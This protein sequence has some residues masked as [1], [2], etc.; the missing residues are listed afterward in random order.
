MRRIHQS[1]PSLGAGHTHIDMLRTSLNLAGTPL[2]VLLLLSA[3]GWPRALTAQSLTYPAAHRDSVI[4]DYHGTKVADPY[5]WLE[6]LDSPRTAEWLKAENRLT[7]DYLGSTLN[8]EAIHRQLTSLWNY[9]RTDVP[10]R[11]AGRLFYVR[12]T[13]LQ[14][15]SVL[16]MQNSLHDPPRS[17]LDPNKISP[18]GSIAVRDYAVSPDGRLLAY[19]TS[20]GGADVG[21]TRVRELSTGRDLAEA[22]HGALTSVCWTHDGR[23][24]FYIRPPAR[25]LEDAAG[26][27]RIEKQLFYHVLGQ[28]QSQDRLIRE[29]KENAKWVYCMLSEDG[30]YAIVVAEQGTESE[31]YAVDLGD[32]KRPDVT[33]PL[34]RLLGD[35]RAFHTPIDIVGSTL[36]VRTNLNAA[37]QRVIALDLGEGASARPRTIIPESSDVIVDA[38]VAGD[39]LAVH[40]LVDVTSRLRLFA[41]DGQPEGEIALPGIGAVGWPLSGRG[42]APELFYSFTSFLAPSTVY[43]HDLRSGASTSFR[44]PRVPFDE[45]AYETRQV[46]YTS[47]NS[48]RV[49][50]FVTTAKNLRLDGTN[51]TL[52]TGYGGYGISIGPSYE[53]DIPLWLE[54]GGIY[55][56]AN[57]RGGGEYGA[58]WHRAGMLERKQNSFDDFIAAAEYLIAERYTAP[59]KLAIYGHSNGGL[60]VGA[61]I[62]QRPDLFAAAVAN[63]GHYD[64]LRYHRFTVG[65]GWIS[66][67]GSPEDPTAFRYLR[68]YSPLH[69]VRT[70]TCYPATL[71]LAADHDDRVVPSHS[72]KFAAVLQAAQGCSRPILLRV[73]TDAS[74]NYASREAQIAERSDLWAFVTAWLGVRGPHGLGGLRKK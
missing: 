60:L 26:S 2:R 70:G 58:D 17:V 28:P 31:M 65:A 16:Y 30:R 73:A 47:K 67:Y 10:W 38:A 74:H 8:R 27:P 9:V 48:P 51:P 3:I 57:L 14:S 5:R 45:S 21:E 37:K 29:W 52:L 36:Y 54:M 6:Q 39:R 44:P 34:I 19:R 69:N 66:E 35:S 41:L 18:D 46:F 4:D 25:K 63:A 71:L 23:G 64:M 56:V 59:G 24:F 7:L 53:P 11:E 40:Y 43:R 62:T 55:A 20:R 33:A 15:Q 32:R 1:R 50:M 61:A 22:V 12:N 49:P 68:A 42:S 72:Y 13:G